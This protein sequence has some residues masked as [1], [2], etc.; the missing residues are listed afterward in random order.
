MTLAFRP[1]DLSARRPE[2]RPHPRPE[3]GPVPRPEPRP[4]PMPGEVPQHDARALTAGGRV[5][6]IRLDGQD[7]VLRITKAGKLI[8]TK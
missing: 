3:P 7:Y 1:G 5:A 8:L 4:E 6:R 2:P